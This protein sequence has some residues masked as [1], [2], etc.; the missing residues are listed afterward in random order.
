MKSYTI[1]W[2]RFLTKLL[3][4]KSSVTIDIVTSDD[5]LT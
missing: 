4:V 5:D 3:M 1:L 2:L